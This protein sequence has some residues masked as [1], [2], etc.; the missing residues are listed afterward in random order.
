MTNTI[1]LRKFAIEMIRNGNFNKAKLA[2][3]KSIK[4][5]SKTPDTFVL[6]GD[7]FYLLKKPYISKHCYIAAMHLQINKF[8]TKSTE[9]LSD[10]LTLKYNK[11]SEE[12]K[13]QLPSKYG[14]IIFDDYTISDHLAHSIIDLEKNIT[15][16]QI[17][18]CSKI[19]K[20][21]ILTGKTIETIINKHN[22]ILEDYLNFRQANYVSLGRSIIIREI[23]WDKIDSDDIIN[24]YLKQE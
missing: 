16:I 11:L 12:T 8:K 1:V 18:E 15:D 9:T 22:I 10:I 14:V 23:K 24:L 13:N 19:Y 21:H 4:L 5:D 17:K 3:L 7:T 20:E 2:L 6:L